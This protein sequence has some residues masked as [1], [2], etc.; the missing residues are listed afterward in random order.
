ML[1]SFKIETKDSI[2][3][4]HR[5]GVDG[6][7]VSAVQNSMNPDV[8]DEKKRRAL[9]NLLKIHGLKVSA[10]CGDLGGYGFRNSRDNERKIAQTIKIIQFAKDLESDIITTHIGVIPEVRNDDYLAIFEACQKLGEYALEMNAYLAIETGSEKIGTLKAFLDE[11]NLKSVKVNYDPAN[12]VMITGDDPVRGVYT[13]KDYIVHTH[14]KDGI[15][16]K[17]VS[18][19]LIYDYL[20]EGSIGDLCLDTY[21]VE[22]PLGEGSV[23]FANYLKALYDIGYTGFLTIEREVGQNPYLD[24]SKA[25]SYLRTII[26]Q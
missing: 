6:V 17:Q 10:V 9:L 21:F 11:L 22:R 26:N 8:L 14:A 15:M 12:L 4:A 18:P 1:D 5:L 13:L 20:A 24:I 19:K 23:D 7:Q 25:V 2:E 16:R 3:A